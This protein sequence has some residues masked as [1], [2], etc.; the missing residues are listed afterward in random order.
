MW[1]AH[2]SVSQRI[3]TEVDGTELHA[4]TESICIL[5]L[6]TSPAYFLEAAL[7]H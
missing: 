6:H 7:A 2:A 1:N 5:H 3:G 4:A